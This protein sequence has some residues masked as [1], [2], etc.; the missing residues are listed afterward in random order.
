[1][2]LKKRLGRQGPQFKKGLRQAEEEKQLDRCMK[3]WFINVLND[4][5][6]INEIL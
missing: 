6:M 5:S 4:D 2:L 1:M 3:E